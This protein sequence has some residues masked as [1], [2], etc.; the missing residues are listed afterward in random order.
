M[1]PYTIIDRSTV[2]IGISTT[3]IAVMNSSLQNENIGRNG[4]NFLSPII[5]LL[6]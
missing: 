5:L 1:T 6:S 4:G 2:Y 3:A